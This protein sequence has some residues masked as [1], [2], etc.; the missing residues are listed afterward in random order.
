MNGNS[1]QRHT[2]LIITTGLFGLLVGFIV[3]TGWVR[4]IETLKSVLP[5]YVS[6]KF[7]SAL[8]FILLST[9]LL[10]HNKYYNKGGHKLTII[11]SFMVLAVGALSFS[12]EVFKYYLGIDELFVTDYKEWL[13]HQPHPGRMSPLTAICFILMGIGLIGISTTKHYFK[14]GSQYL[15]HLVTVIVFVAIV[16]YLYNVPVF[17]NLSHITTMALPSAIGFLV[18]SLSAALINPNLGLTL[19]FTGNMMGNYLARTLF[20]KMLLAVL[21]LGYLHLLLLK[22]NIISQ[23]LGIVLLMISFIFISL[24]L[25]LEKSALLNRLEFKMK[26][27]EENFKI[28]VESAPYAMIL[29]NAEGKIMHTNFQ[30]ENLYGYDDGELLGKSVEL[31][32]PAKLHAQHRNISTTFF[33]S[34]AVMSFGIE[35]NVYAQRKDGST[36]PVE[37]ILTPITTPD[38]VI[39]LASVIDITTRKANDDIITKQLIEL[40][41]KN[42]ELEQFN[43]IASHD[44][45]E[46]LRT[47]SNYILL[48]EEDYPEQINDEIK[49]HLTTMNAAVARMSL[50]VRS[51]LDFGRLGRNKK[52]ALTNCNIVVN[53]VISDLN[54]LIKSSGAVV[55]I[56]N[57]LPLLYAYETELRQL[58]QN[59]INNAIKFK[60]KNT[61]PHITIG[62]KKIKGFYEFSVSDNGIGIDVKH[63]TSIFNIFQ[64]LHKNEDYEGYGIGLANC[65]KITEMHGGEIWVKSEINKGSTFTFKILNFKA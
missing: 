45:Q 48:L 56:K 27:A 52:L 58:F 29:S 64:R 54:G 44:L 33:S 17:Y 26:T 2:G 50:L 31:I 37:T 32:I 39:T 22:H 10:I 34:P 59:L 60:K 65:R 46:P 24:F 28:S 53:N 38:G 40:Q 49:I 61:V 1:S 55:T 3:L 9:T 51:L 63:Y 57:D 36:F 6:M 11:L 41:I 25:I 43:Y 18:L 12:Q 21:L 8:C 4:D 35:D 20:P 13:L 16:G 23:E 7:N 5:R 47:V 30:A 14:V 15:F 42:Q 62:C 19:V